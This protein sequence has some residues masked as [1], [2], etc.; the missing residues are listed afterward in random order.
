MQGT[1]KAK[2]SLAIDL[3]TSSVKMLLLEREGAVTACVRR[4]YETI[5]PAEGRAE[6]RPSDWIAAICD[7]AQELAGQVGQ[8]CMEQVCA[9][10]LSA[11]MPT[12]VLAD[13]EGAALGNAIVWSDSRANA[14]AQAK[15]EEFGAA[16]HYTLTGVVLDGHYI[17]PMYAWLC[18]HEPLRT[19][20]VRWILSA[21]DYLCLW[22]CGRAITDPSTASGF[23]VYNLRSKSWEP[24][25]CALFGIPQECLP[26]IL[27]SDACCGAVRPEAAQLLH[28]PETA[29][30]SNG[31]ADSVCGVFGVGGSD[32]GT[33]CQIWGSSTAV[34]CGTKEPVYSPKQQFFITPTAQEDAYAVEADLLSTGV[35]HMW[36]KQLLHGHHLRKDSG[37]DPPD[38]SQLAAKAPAGSDGL[39]FFPYLSGGEQSVLWDPYLQGGILGLR[40]C[41]TRAHLARALLEGMCFETR[42]ILAAFEEGGC[43]C[44][45]VVCTGSVVN[46]T[47]FMQLLAD[48]LGIPCSAVCEN[49]GSAL[50]AAMLA[51]IT[52]GMWTWEEIQSLTRRKR[53]TFQADADR[54][55]F[56][57]SRYQ[58][59]IWYATRAKVMPMEDLQI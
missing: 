43:V 12:L 31:A 39:F 2:Y 59:Y 14:I 57:D 32:E 18:G 46:D 27:P 22:L 11:Q 29:V 9:V 44:R 33:V 37:S 47:F 45:E 50:G 56:Y 1:T 51:G 55:K 42:R 53:L 34:L 49:N 20:K 4:P 15:L 24:S 7:A 48:V 26:E 30:V 17:A 23:G 16:R 6:Q 54:K 13:A 38:L 19:S 8:S 21:K 41:H 25:A 52:G 58:Q 10:G 40:L 5:S 36:L 28:L 3:G 35:S